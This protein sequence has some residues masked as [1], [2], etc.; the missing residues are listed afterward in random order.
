M[1]KIFTTKDGKL[2]IYVRQD[3]YKGKL[4]SNNWVGRTFIQGKD[5]IKSSGFTDFKKAKEFLEK[6]YVELHLLK[7]HNLLIHDNSFKDCSKEF[8]KYISTTT[9]FYLYK[10]HKG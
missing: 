1:S 9:L 7:K 4:K 8:L 5:K 10:S 3:K 2:H 6:W